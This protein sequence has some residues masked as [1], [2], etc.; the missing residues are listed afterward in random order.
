MKRFDSFTNITLPETVEE[1]AKVGV[2]QSKVQKHLRSQ[3]PS[4]TTAVKN[5]NGGKVSTTFSVKLKM[6]RVRTKSDEEE[7][8]YCLFH[9][10]SAS[11]K[12]NRR[13]NVNW[14]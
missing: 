4:T 13:L 7:S 10:S 9:S 14:S 6:R 5:H 2:L 12:A 1:Q 11:I 3:P 8:V